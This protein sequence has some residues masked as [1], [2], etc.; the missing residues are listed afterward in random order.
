LRLQLDIEKRF[1][2]VSQQAEAAFPV[3]SDAETKYQE[4]L[5][6][7]LAKTDALKKLAKNARRL[8]TFCFSPVAAVFTSMLQVAE[9]TN[10]MESKPGSCGS[11]WVFFFLLFSRFR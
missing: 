4:S 1:K 8:F 2:V 7:L 10:R 9:M 3:L 6:S 11:F 5:Q